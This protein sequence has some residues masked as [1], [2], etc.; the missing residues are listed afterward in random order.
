MTQCPAFNRRSRLV[1]TKRFCTAFNAACEF[2][3]TDCRTAIHFSAIAL[4]GV[5]EKRATMLHFIK[6]KNELYCCTRLLLPKINQ[7]KTVEKC[8]H[9]LVCNIT[10]CCK[11]TVQIAHN[12]L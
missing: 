12:P 1:K 5:K 11:I 2:T 10:Q 9:F 3:C 4:G 7:S 8:F 6:A